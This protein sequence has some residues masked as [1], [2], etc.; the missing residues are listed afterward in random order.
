MLRIDPTRHSDVVSRAVTGG[1]AARSPLVASWA[2]SARL[3]GLDPAKRRPPE[4]LT[5]AELAVARERMGP[6]IRAAAP[7]L[8]Q[9]FLSVGGV[10]C[11]VLLADR[12]GVPLDR[13]GAAVDDTTFDDW[14][15]WTGALWSEECEGTNGIGTCLA[16]GR[17]VTIHR[18][19][20]FLT[21]NTVL[22]C[23][24]APIHDAEGN[25]AGALD[26][27]SCRADLTEGFAR[28]IA[29]SVAGAARQIEAESFRAAYGNCR[30]V[31]VPEADRVQTALLAVDADDLVV[32]ATRAARQSLGLSGDLRRHPRPARDLLGGTAADGLD[33]AE[34]AALVRALARAGGNVSAAAR[35]L[36]ISR[37]TFHRKLARH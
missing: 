37:A 6:M 29:Q 1:A 18:D 8:D 10:G 36:G 31:L 34:R 35:A 11:C 17:P 23:M 13:R 15:L 3:H 21:R 27:S 33:D 4:R 5:E 25:L 12:D 16:E 30:I 32:G 24:S 2:R 9:L 28:L 22:S 20:H 19:Q 7:S 14:G 26:V